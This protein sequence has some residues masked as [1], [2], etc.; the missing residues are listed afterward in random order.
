[1]RRLCGK[2]ITSSKGTIFGM[3]AYMTSQ[4]AQAVAQT[5]GKD[6]I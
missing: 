5:E 6:G 2:R 1:M 3:A 4:T